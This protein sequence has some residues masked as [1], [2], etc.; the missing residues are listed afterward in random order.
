MIVDSNQAATTNNE[1][2]ITNKTAMTLNID[3]RVSPIAQ[4]GTT[5]VK[6]NSPK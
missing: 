2:N 1:L 6:I 3:G 5:A 4:K